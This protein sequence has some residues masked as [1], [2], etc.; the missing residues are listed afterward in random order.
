DPFPYQPRQPLR[1][2][3]A[4]RD[5]QLHLRLPELRVFTGDADVARHRE[6]TATA[7]GESVDGGDHRLAARLESSEHA[8]PALRAR[9]AV[10][11]PLP[12]QIADVGAGDERVRAPAGKDGAVD[13]DPVAAA[14]DC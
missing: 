11:R 2:A 8:L 3:V 7:Q 13:V 4:G 12:R 10:E 6:L 1:A 5:S 9:L 14:L